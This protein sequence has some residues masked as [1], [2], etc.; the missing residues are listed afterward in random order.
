MKNNKTLAENISEVSDM[1]EKYFLD[2][3]I[4]NRPFGVFVFDMQPGHIVHTA[5][6]SPLSEQDVITL[7][8]LWVNNEKNRVQGH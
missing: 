5:F 3:G 2:E 7:I 8:S 6:A 1:V 4:T